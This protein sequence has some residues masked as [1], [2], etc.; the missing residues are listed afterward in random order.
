MNFDDAFDRL[1]GHEGGYSNHPDDPGAETMW[2]I[3][4][5]TA[6]RNGYFGE[7]RALPKDTAKEIARRQYWDAVSADSMPAAVRFDLF[8]GA[9]NS[10]PKQAIKWLQRACF[11]DDDGVV[12]PRTLMA[13]NT[14]HGQALAARYN[15]Y[16][17][18][19]MTDLKT[20]PVF[21]RGWS[22]RVAANLI[23]T[24]G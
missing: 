14:Y 18:D 8:D 21:G 19:M 7:M 1:M 10:G 12:G 2:G 11:V 24:K 15:G 5:D 20:W 23:N 6:K 22:K 9:Y 13:A 17:L 3:T 16:R 4:H